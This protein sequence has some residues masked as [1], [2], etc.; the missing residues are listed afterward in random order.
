M[1]NRYSAFIDFLGAFLVLI[2]TFHIVIAKIITTAV[3]EIMVKYLT[4]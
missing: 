2:V 1:I 3:P 4:K